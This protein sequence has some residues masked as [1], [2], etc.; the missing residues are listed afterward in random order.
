MPE[1]LDR[2]GMGRACALKRKTERATAVSILLLTERLRPSGIFPKKMPPRMTFKWQD[3]NRNRT[4]R[5]ELKA[6]E[7]RAAGHSRTEGI[8]G[9]GASRS[10]GFVEGLAAL[11]ESDRLETEGVTAGGDHCEWHRRAVRFGMHVFG[12]K[13]GAQPGIENFRLPLPEVWIQSALNIEVIEL[14]FDGRN[15]FLEVAP[16]VGLTNVKPGNSATF[17]VGL[18][19]H[20]LPALQRRT[21]LIQGVRERIPL[22]AVGFAMRNASLGNSPAGRP[23]LVRSCARFPA[24][25]RSIP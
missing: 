13:P 5:G 4:K 10:V 2:S 21:T 7:W 19:N 6:G 23:K 12:L 16:H 3:V 20:R 22:L 25:S 9:P 18:Y 17:G 24:V 15:M 11:M 14:Q 8:R 1:G